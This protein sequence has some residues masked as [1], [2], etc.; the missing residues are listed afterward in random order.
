MDDAWKQDWP[1]VVAGFGS[2]H[3]DDQAGW[4]VA[5]LLRR[6]PDVPARVV[7]VGEPTQLL[8]ALRGSLRLIL[9]D[10]CHTG[11]VAGAVTR[12]DWPDPRIAVGH[13]HSTHGV[14]VVDVLK[15]AER[16]GDLPPGVEI[17]G[18]EAADC[19]PGRGLTPPVLEAVAEVE[20]TIVETLRETVH[21]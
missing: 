8:D 13:R 3:G 1:T 7:V 12:L 21:A 9:V 15:L 11:G 6:R 17:F 20:E 19:S 16:L 2:P 18:I 10:A 14:S 4:R 5:A